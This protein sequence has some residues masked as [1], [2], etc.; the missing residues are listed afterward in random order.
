MT[1]RGNIREQMPLEPI[2]RGEE[3]PLMESGVD[4]HDKAGWRG[5]GGCFTCRG[6]EAY[7]LLV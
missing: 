7:R 4:Q 2:L 5:G 1:S 6:R 3:D